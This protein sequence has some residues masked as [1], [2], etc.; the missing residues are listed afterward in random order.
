V[1]DVGL[2]NGRWGLIE[3]NPIHSAGWYAADLERVIDA[4]FAFETDR[5]AS[6]TGARRDD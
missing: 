2:S 5:R 3:F 4:Y 1:T 6:H